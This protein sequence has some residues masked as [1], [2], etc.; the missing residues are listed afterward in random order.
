VVISSEQRAA[1][2][3]PFPRSSSRSPTFCRLDGNLSH[4]ITTNLM[5]S[6]EELN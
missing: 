1:M 2:A 4:I 5:I 3:P 6:G